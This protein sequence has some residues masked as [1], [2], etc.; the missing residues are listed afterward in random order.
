MELQVWVTAKPVLPSPGDGTVNNG[1]RGPR[2]AGTG[3]GGTRQAWAHELSPLECFPG[4]YHRTARQSGPMAGPVPPPWGS[5]R[6]VTAG[7]T[8]PASV[9]LSLFW[10]HGRDRCPPPRPPP[11]D[12]GSV[13][14]GEHVSQM[15]GS[16]G[17]P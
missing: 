15:T 7:T 3:G 17:R 8:I 9:A 2:P 11:M 5:L 16:V 12:V 14:A 4:H 6:E 13:A 10:R 1:R